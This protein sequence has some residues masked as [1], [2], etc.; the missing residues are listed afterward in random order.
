MRVNGRRTARPQPV[1]NV[2]PLVDVVL[3]LLIIFMVVIPAMETAGRIDLPGMLNVDADPKSKTD[4]WTL[5]LSSDGRMFFEREE[6]TPER[7]RARLSA[8]LLQDP[9]RRLILRAD[10]GAPY[11]EVRAL[12]AAC[13]ELG[14]P[15]ISLRVNE[16]QGA[17]HARQETTAHPPTR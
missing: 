13:Q 3:V 10:R 15:G 12:F 16:L 1:I 7:F 4:P 14:F 8:A 17:A 6:L 11:R 9:T 2:T 5:A